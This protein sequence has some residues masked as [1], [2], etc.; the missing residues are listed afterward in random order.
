[1][2]APPAR[3]R[4]RRHD[5][6]RRSRRQRYAQRSLDPDRQGRTPSSAD[7]ESEPWDLRWRRS[8]FFPSD[9]FFFTRMVFSEWFFFYPLEFERVRSN[10]MLSEKEKHTQHFFFSILGFF[11]IWVPSPVAKGAALI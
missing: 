5:L 8:F 3:A 6:P 11:F 10:E 2:V 4:P 9:N 7:K 1:V